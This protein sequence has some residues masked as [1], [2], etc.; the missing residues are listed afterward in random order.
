MTI[1]PRQLECFIA[2][3]EE[4][5]LNRAAVRL[6]MTQPPLTRRIQNLEQ[7][8]GVRLFHRTAGGMELTEPGTVLLERA[9]RILALS[10]H[11]VERTRLAGVGEVGRLSV[12]YYDTAILD[13]IP[14]LLRQF[15]SRH[16]DITISLERVRKATQ[17]D[18]LR[19]RLL[20]VGFGEQ[21]GTENGITCRTVASEPLYVAYAERGTFADRPSVTVSDLRDS[22]F[23]L[24]PSSR[25]GFADAVVGMCFN[26][27]FSPSVAI[28]AE[29]VVACLSY[30]AIGSGIAV[31]PKSATHVRPGD[32]M[33]VPLQDAAPAKVSCVYL[34]SN[35]SPTLTRFVDFLNDQDAVTTPDDTAPAPR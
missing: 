12:G 8:V 15:T 22:P 30:V 16:P 6:H 13:G 29:D 18:Y 27:G 20:H 9:Y 14:T 2:V 24:Y 17:I 1:D 32:V 10:T 34:A 26:N 28:E 31:V 25:P 5:N 11:A 21:Y 4:L 3:A 7:D 33:F 19:D 35:H 23:V